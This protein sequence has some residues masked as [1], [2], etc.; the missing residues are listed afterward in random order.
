MPLKILSYEELYGWTMDAIVKQVCVNRF[1][2]WQAQVSLTKYYIQGFFS[3]KRYRNSQEGKGQT[4][5][6]LCN[7]IIK[8][9]ANFITIV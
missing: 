9:F 7:N 1:L 8:L 4:Y 5:R 6:K 3:G 2:H